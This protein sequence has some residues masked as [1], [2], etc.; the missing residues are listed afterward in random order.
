MNL[1][2]KALILKIRFIQKI[3][4]PRSRDAANTR[5][6]LCI[7]VRKIHRRHQGDKASLKVL[8]VLSINF[9]SLKVNFYAVQKK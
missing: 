8:M 7:H 2:Q 6:C 5:L 1:T 9:H 3:Q 4:F